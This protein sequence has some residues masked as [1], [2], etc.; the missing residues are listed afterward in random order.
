PAWCERLIVYE[1]VDG[2]G[3][4]D[5]IELALRVFAERVQGGDREAEG[6]TV[7]Q[8]PRVSGL[9]PAASLVTEEITAALGRHLGAAVD[10]TADDRG[11]DATAV[12]I[13][14]E[15][16]F[17]GALDALVL[18]AAR[19]AEVALVMVPAVV[20]RCAADPG[21][22]QEVDLLAVG[23]ADAGDVQVAG[24][25]VERRAPG[26]AQPVADDLPAVRVVAEG[27][28]TFRY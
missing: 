1:L 20:L 3:A 4:R 25:A 9:D 23:L 19:P 7:L 10:E 22:V 17:A 24:H 5:D 27:V 26:V 12:R 18:R 28:C 2:P 15:D 14:R 11:S 16:Q 6:L 13:L 21:G 8:R